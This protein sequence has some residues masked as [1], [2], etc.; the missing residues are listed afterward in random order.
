MHKV[1]ENTS[2]EQ[3][4]C[5][6]TPICEFWIQADKE[7]NASLADHKTSVKRFVCLKTTYTY[8]YVNSINIVVSA[9]MDVCMIA[10]VQRQSLAHRPIVTTFGLNEIVIWTFGLVIWDN[11]H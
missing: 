5:E 6:I 10:E 4:Y 3:K 2:L 11:P 8:M 7:S 1:S 9:L